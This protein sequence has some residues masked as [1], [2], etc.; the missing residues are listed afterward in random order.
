[1]IV[2]G[3]RAHYSLSKCI[4]RTSRHCK[5]MAIMWVELESPSLCDWP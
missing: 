2:L 5:H 3:E 4:Y 1:M